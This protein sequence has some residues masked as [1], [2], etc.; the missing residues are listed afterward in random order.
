MS[1]QV[2]PSN[3]RDKIQDVLD[4]L[5]SNEVLFDPKSQYTKTQMIEWCGSWIAIYDKLPKYVAN[6]RERPG[7]R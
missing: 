7:N 1:Q 6:P 2:E 5:L 3:T 4:V